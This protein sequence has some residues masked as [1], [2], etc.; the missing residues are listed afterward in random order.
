MRD[1][2]KIAGYVLGLEKERAP[3]N[4]ERLPQIERRAGQ[5]VAQKALAEAKR[6]LDRRSASGRER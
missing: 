3:A 1:A 5:E 2:D 6:V 4:I